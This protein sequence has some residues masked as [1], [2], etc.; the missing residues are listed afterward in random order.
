LD[1]SFLQQVGTSEGAIARRQEHLTAEVFL[2]YSAS[3]YRL[4]PQ[5]DGLAASLGATLVFWRVAGVR[6]NHQQGGSM[7]YWA[8]VFLVIAIIAGIFGF[9][10]IAAAAAGI[11]KL[12]FVIFLVLFVIA[13]ISHLGRRGSPGI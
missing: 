9:A 8:L 4:Q 13:L 12:L 6:S 5:P 2:P 1:G 7:L 10:G 11:A 3:K